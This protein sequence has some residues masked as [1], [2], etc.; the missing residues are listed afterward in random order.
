[1]AAKKK[2]KQ[3]LDPQ[4]RPNFV[5]RE[6]LPDTKAVRTEFLFNFI[7]LFLATISLGYAAY[8]RY[9][10]ITTERVTDVVFREVEAG[11]AANQATVNAYRDYMR[12]G[13]SLNEIEDFASG[14]I[15]YSRYFAALVA[16]KPDSVLLT[17][18]NIRY[19][20]RVEGRRRTPVV[21]LV[22]EGTLDEM[23]GVSPSEVI[24]SFQQSAAQLPLEGAELLENELTRFA[25]D[26]RLRVFSF[27]LEIVFATGKK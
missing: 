5:I 10:L 16:Q 1:M 25:R 19:D 14:A 20:T 9:I 4:W 7:A 18:V 2:S 8:Q 12:T 22:I 17:R 21:R 15:D 13:K 3:R 27:G 24:S 26:N 6:Q 11:R 23:P